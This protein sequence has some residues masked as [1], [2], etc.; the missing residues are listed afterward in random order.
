MEMHR[1]TIRNG[2]RAVVVPTG[3]LAP[4]SL[5][6][7]LSAGTSAEKE[8]EWGLA[9][10]NKHM[11]YKG[12]RDFPDSRSLEREFRLLGD[13]QNAGTSKEAVFYHILVGR[14]HVRKALHIFSDMLI[15][16]PMRQDDLEKERGAIF[17]QLKDSNDV[18]RSAAEIEFGL[19]FFGEHPL[20]RDTLGSEALR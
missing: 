7:W 19:F 2:V 8:T 15:S 6:V 3:D 1:F 5:Q 11:I 16:S 4:V 9:H 10:F 14:Q 13:M 12:D 17:Q 18:P 20:G